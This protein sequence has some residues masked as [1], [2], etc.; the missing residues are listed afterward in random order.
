M[1]KW[2]KRG[3]SVLLVITFLMTM[4]S[5]CGEKEP[6]LLETLES[7]RGYSK[8][9]SQEEYEFYKYFV[10]RDLPEK[11]SDEEL[12]ILVKEYANKVNAA[13]YLGNKLELCE[14]YSFQTL[15]FR[16]EQENADRMAKLEQ[17]EVVYGLEQFNLKTYFQYSMDNLQASL[18][19]YLE[20]NADA[21]MLK[22]AEKYYEDHKDEFRYR[23]KV[24]YEETIGDVSETLT[25]DPDQLSFLGKADKGLA[26]FLGGAEIGDTYE[27]IQESGNRKVVIKEITYSEDG[28]EN[29][30]DMALYRLVRNEL[31]DQLITKVAENNPVE[32]E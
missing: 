12:D 27:D 17:N 18:M 2:C 31:Y 22:M 24:V 4:I 32:F 29:H 26:D 14:A 19:G 8:V 16:L 20:A 9:I 28:Y 21:E 1:K 30:A 13:F 23:T 15:K 7:Y 3:L 25:A 10:E 6:G 11:I 5:G